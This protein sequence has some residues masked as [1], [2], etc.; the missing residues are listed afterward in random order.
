MVYLFLKWIHIILNEAPNL[1]LLLKFFLKR[2]KITLHVSICY[3][4]GKR[5]ICC[6]EDKWKS[7]IKTTLQKISWVCVCVCV[8]KL[9]SYKNDVN[10]RYLLVIGT[11]V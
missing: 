11:D 3:Y 7:K 9:T 4:F 6:L 8:C 2:D 5:K 10:Q 1:R